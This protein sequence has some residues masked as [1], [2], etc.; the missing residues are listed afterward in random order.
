MRRLPKPPVPDYAKAIAHIA[1]PAV[2]TFISEANAHYL[3][4]D[5]LRR[6][7]RPQGLSEAAAWTAVT[8]SRSAARRPAPI[9]DLAGRHFQY[10]LPETAARVIH[11]I[12]RQGGGAFAADPSLSGSISELRDRVVI[13]SLMEE[14]IASSQIEGAVTTRAVAKEMLRTGR[15]PENRSEQ[16]IANGYATILL[17]KERLDRPLSVEL[18][19][20]I[21]ESMT[22]GTLDRAGDSGR[23]RTEEDRVEVIDLRDNEVVF[24]PPPA[25]QLPHRLRALIEFA[26]ARPGEEPFV[27]P[28]V[29]ASILHFWVAYEHPFV[30]GNGRTARAIFYWS[31]LKSGYWLFEFL[32]ISRIIHA[33]P[34]RYYRAFLYTENYDND[35]TYFLMFQLEVTHKALNELHDRIRGMKE[36]LSRISGLRVAIDLNLRQ[37]A[38]LDHALRHPTH[39]YT[40]KSHQL[41]HGITHQ[42]ARTDL[43]ALVRKKLLREAYSGR[44]RQFMPAKDLLTRLLGKRL[45]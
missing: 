41:S 23:L 29:R 17:L 9:I 6:R 12:D 35:L 22:Q 32:T 19:C 3:G 18:L 2:K 11:E 15:K 37:K 34:M 44:P 28:L 31:M 25:G 30:D 21:Q 5:E 40:V 13:D 1:D 45:T 14:A 38:L 4:W 24:T 10:M 27:H 7:P 39:V 16:M 36:Q 26:N 42:T 20:E 8:I 33:A 43:L